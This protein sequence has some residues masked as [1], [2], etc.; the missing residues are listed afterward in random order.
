MTGENSGW[1]YSAKIH[2]HFHWLP[3]VDAQEKVKELFLF[4]ALVETFDKRM[5]DIFDIHEAGNL[6]RRHRSRYAAVFG[7]IAKYMRAS[8]FSNSVVGEVVEFTLAL[9][10]LDDGTVRDFLRPTTKRGRPSDAGDVWAARAH[11][12]IAIDAIMKNGL[13]RAD[14]CRRLAHDFGFLAPAL[15][16]SSSKGEFATAMANWH[17]AFSE[18]AVADIR[19]QEMYKNRQELFA[20]GMTVENIMTAAIISAAFST[21]TETYISLKKQHSSRIKKHK[22]KRVWE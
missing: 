2:A 1:S 21:S 15:S 14:A 3:P 4:R 5:N 6:P 8:G 20:R 7:E 17:S 12:A 13:T 16:P 11:V 9:Y 22:L 10:E 19:S 18:G